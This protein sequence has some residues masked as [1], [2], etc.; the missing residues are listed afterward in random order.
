[1]NNIDSL[2]ITNVEYIFDSSA[3]SLACLEIMLD[4]EKSKTV[5]NQDCIEKIESLEAYI[6]ELK[7]LCMKK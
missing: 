6:K 3:L 4:S 7:D 1:M 5:L 2:N